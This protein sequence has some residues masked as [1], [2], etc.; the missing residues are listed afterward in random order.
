MF[1]LDLSWLAFLNRFARQSRLLDGLLLK[2][3]SLHLFKGGILLA[4]FWWAWFSTRLERPRARRAVLAALAG[5]LAALALTQVLT[6][7][8]PFRPRPIHNPALAFTLPYG[9]ETI[10]TEHMSSFP[11]DHAA[12]FGALATGLFFISR[13]LGIA[14]AVYVFLVVLF[15]RAYLGLH[16]PTDLLA[17]AA[18]G[19]AAGLACQIRGLRD[20][21]ARPFLSWE[22]RWPGPFYAFLFL[23]MY[24]LAT[25]FDDTRRALASLRNLIF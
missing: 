3:S 14:A 6:H 7:A 20:R 23:F 4:V 22:A 11:S 13:P 8:L 10:R 24:Q 1:P 17:G 5:G 2:V 19:L 9:A 18:I 16:Y 15:P 25:M 21:I 12:L